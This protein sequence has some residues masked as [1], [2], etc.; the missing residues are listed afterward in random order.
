ML[1]KDPRHRYASPMELVNDLLW[2]ARASGLRQAA[3]GG[4]TWTVPIAPVVPSYYRHLPW[5]VSLLALV[6]IVIALDY[7]WPQLPGPASP[8]HA[9]PPVETDGDPG[10]TRPAPT[11]AIPVHPTPP[12]GT[13]VGVGSLAPAKRTGSPP[14]PVVPIL[15]GVEA[16]VRPSSS[17]S[18][19]IPVAGAAAEKPGVEKTAIPAVKPPGDDLRRRI[20]R[21]TATEEVGRAQRTSAHY[22]HERSRGSLKFACLKSSGRF[23]L[24]LQ[25]HDGCAA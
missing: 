5:I 24:L 2:V 23:C 4:R 15:P 3:S 14:A 9:P 10:A 25:R 20:P 17:A 11:P 21:I 22:E 6:A 1:A 7:L 13:G 12:D 8:S 18:A 16:P 19:T